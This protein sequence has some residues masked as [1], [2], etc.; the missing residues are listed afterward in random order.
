MLF[1]TQQMFLHE[2]NVSAPVLSLRLV[3]TGDRSMHPAPQSTATDRRAGRQL[4][5]SP[6]AT[7]VPCKLPRLLL[8]PDSSPQPQS[9]SAAEADDRGRHHSL[10]RALQSPRDPA[11]CS[12][13]TRG[14]RARCTCCALMEAGGGA[15]PLAAQPTAATQVHFCGPQRPRERWRKS[16][17][18]GPRQA[19]FFRSGLQRPRRLHPE[20]HLPA[21]G[22]PRLLEL[23]P[24]AAPRRPE[25]RLRSQSRP[26]PGRLSAS[27]R[28]PA[29]A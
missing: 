28:R 17:P 15:H 9:S 6:F 26:Q 11:L 19:N 1:K 21:A 3:C 23:R 20:S 16:A 13:S 7:D 27:C 8:G 12:C 5:G 4:P 2:I 14:C 10:L 25:T 18:Y 22:A 29:A 24:G